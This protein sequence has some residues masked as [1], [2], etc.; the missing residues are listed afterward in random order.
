[1]MAPSANAPTK[2]R[3]SLHPADPGHKFWAKQAGIGRL[4]GQSP[5]GSETDVDC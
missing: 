2:L 1:M 5:D 4:V 3:H